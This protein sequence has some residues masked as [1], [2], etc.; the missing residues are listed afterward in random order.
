MDYIMQGGHHVLLLTIRRRRNSSELRNVAV[1]GWRSWGLRGRKGDDQQ[2]EHEMRAQDAA[3]AVITH[4]SAVKVTHVRK[5]HGID[6]HQL[7]KV[8]ECGFVPD[9]VTH[10]LPS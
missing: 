2:G 6:T 7:L 8:G 3:C 9:S 4:C 5:R 1:E 10:S